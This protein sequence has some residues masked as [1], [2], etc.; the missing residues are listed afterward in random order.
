[1]CASRTSSPPARRVAGGEV[2]DAFRWGS[3]RVSDA[4]EVSEA[5]AHGR[6]CGGGTRGGAGRSGAPKWIL[7]EPGEFLEGRNGGRAGGF[8][9][10]MSQK[11]RLFRALERVQCEGR[12][13]LFRNFGCFENLE[14]AFRSVCFNF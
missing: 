9:V 2:G 7:A 10:L 5:A 3:G 4:A 13:R 12:G 6:G 1:L 8:R 14:L 11:W